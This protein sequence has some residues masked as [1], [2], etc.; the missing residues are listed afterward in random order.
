MRPS[1]LPSAL[2]LPF[3]LAWGGFGV[4]DA[5]E[6]YAQLAASAPDSL[7]AEVTF[8]SVWSRVRSTHF[9]PE[10]G[11]VDWEGVREELRPRALAA[12]STAELRGVLSE[13]LGRLG[14]SHFTIIPRASAPAFEGL[15]G[16]ASAAGDAEPGIGVRWIEGDLLVASVREG[17]PAARSGLR[18]GWAIE[19][20]DGTAV[21]SLATLVREAAG[22]EDDRG[23][24]AVWLH[25][26]VRNRLRGVEGSEVE[27]AVRDERSLRRTLRVRRVTAAGQT[28][29]FGNLPPVR[30]ETE[31]RIE[32]LDGGLEVGILRFT[33]WFPAIVPAISDAMDTLRGTDAIV[34]DLRGNPG[35]VG[36]LVMGL[37]GHFLSEPVSLGTMRTRD[38]SLEFVVNP[39]TVA[40]DG[41]R[42]EP[43]GGPLLIL[44]DPLTASTSEIFAG[45]LQA[46]GRATVVGE[47]S[48]GQA[49]PALVVPLP[50]GDLLMHAVA[51]F[52]GP[53]GARLEGHGVQ[54]DVLAP[55]DRATLLDQEDPVLQE[56]FRWIQRQ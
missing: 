27:L 4:S 8:D 19:E 56:A 51:D 38:T 49:L 32:R 22:P 39:Q 35:G 44:V 7:R 46:L 42:V 15:L 20:I 16:E 28:V 30:L 26:A 10:L 23:R 40:P 53:D 52:V 1:R 47:P 37:G 50:N 43:Y 45:G 34:L 3:A 14:D 6:G 9:D 48:A 41:R 13:M 18:P 29:R 33:A 17:S 5:R 24:L 25:A 55:V 36:G 12:S 11:G 54:P 2:L 31:R 21:D